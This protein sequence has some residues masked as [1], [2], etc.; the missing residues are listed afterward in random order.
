MEFTTHTITKIDSLQECGRGEQNKAL[1][2]YPSPAPADL[3]RRRKPGEVG[4]RVCASK[5]ALRVRV[6]V[7]SEQTAP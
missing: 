2:L 5:I 3:V 7:R 6:Q 1:S 4:E